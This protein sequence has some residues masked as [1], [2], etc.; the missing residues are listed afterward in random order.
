MID[1][2]RAQGM[3]VIERRIM[4]DELPNFNECFIV[5]SAAEVTPVAEIGPYRFK[6][7]HYRD[8]T[9]FN[10]DNGFFHETTTARCVVP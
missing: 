7:G 10:P 6:P 3:D 1:L 9:L 8:R 2:A 5:G 4:P